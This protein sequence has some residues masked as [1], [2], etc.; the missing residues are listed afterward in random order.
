MEYDDLKLI[1]K[2]LEEENKILF[3]QL[4]YNDDICSLG[5]YD[6]KNDSKYYKIE[7]NNIRSKQKEMLLN[8]S[9][10]IIKE[11]WYIDGNENSGNKLIEFFTKM[12]I[13]NFNITSDN[14]MD[15]INISNFN[16]V[17]N[18]LRILYKNYNSEL[19][20]HKIELSVD[21]LKLKFE[22][23]KIRLDIYVAEENEREEIL[24]QKEI[25]R[26][27]VKAEKEIEQNR[28]KL[29]KQLLHYKIQLSKGDNVQKEINEI[30]QKLE[31]DNNLLNNSKAGWVYIINSASFGENVYKIGISRR[32]NI[33]ER[34]AELSGS[35]VPSKLC[36]IV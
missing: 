34:F 7:L 30:E 25:I 9:Y 21:Y 29:E 24:H 27:Q 13:I 17:R 12:C 28:N 22:E 26:E 35:N 14:L 18:K 31:L 5:L 33:E 11:K 15:K 36:L 20:K 2:Q 8:K 10:F 32:L 23:I 6:I 19:S 16:E 3:D 1:I 4:N